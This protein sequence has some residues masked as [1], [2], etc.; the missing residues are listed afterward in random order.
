MILVT[1]TGVDPGTMMVHLHNTS[2]TS[3]TV[4]GARRLNKTSIQQL[5][6]QYSSPSR[7]HLESLALATELQLLPLSLRSWGPAQGQEPGACAEG[8]GEVVQGEAGET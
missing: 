6:R 1:H 2:P 7:A 4:M 5:I 3:P 8:G